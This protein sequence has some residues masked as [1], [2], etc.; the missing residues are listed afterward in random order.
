MIWMIE[1]DFFHWLGF[2]SMLYIAFTY[3]LLQMGFFTYQLLNLVG[4][5]VLIVSLLVYFNLGS[6][7]IEIFWVGITLYATFKNLKNKMAKKFKVYTIIH[8]IIYNI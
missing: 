2:T 4:A 3:L 7:L 6:F 1:M 8:K 5:I